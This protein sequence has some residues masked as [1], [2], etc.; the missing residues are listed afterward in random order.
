MLGSSSWTPVG[1]YSLGGKMRRRLAALNRRIG[2]PDR[3][4]ALSTTGR[5]SCRMWCSGLG[6]ACWL[7]L[8]SWTSSACGLASPAQAGGASLV[9]CPATVRRLLQ[10]YPEHPL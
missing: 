5:E 6:F 4:L 3:V 10:R 2:G 9:T 7:L 8:P 1:N